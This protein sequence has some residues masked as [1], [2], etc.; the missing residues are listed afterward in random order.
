M[1]RMMLCLIAG[2]LFLA[3][4]AVS[5]DPRY[6]YEFPWQPSSKVVA[7][8]LHQA[9][10]DSPPAIPTSK[11]IRIEDATMVLESGV[12]DT[13]YIA[14]DQIVHFKF[15]EITHSLVVEPGAYLLPDSKESLIWVH[16]TGA[17]IR[18]GAPGGEFVQ[19]LGDGSWKKNIHFAINVAWGASAIMR[20]VL[21]AGVQLG[22]EVATERGDRDNP[23]SLDAVN[24]YLTNN[25]QGLRVLGASNVEVLQAAIWDN[26]DLAVYVSDGSKNHD[27]AVRFQATESWIKGKSEFSLTVPSS[28]VVFDQCNL[29]EEFVE[30]LYSQPDDLGL[31][32]VT[33][34]ENRPITGVVQTWPRPG[35]ILLSMADFTGNGGVGVEDAELF[36]QAFGSS[37]DSIPF[38][39]LYD[40]NNDGIVN[41]PDM[42]DLAYAFAGITR[43]EPVT[44]LATSPNMPEFLSVITR[45]PAIVSA[46][47]ADAGFG[48][49]VQAYLDIQTAVAAIGGEVPGGFTLSQNYPNPFNPETTIRF[50]LPQEASV[51]LAVYNT[52]G[53]VVARL[54]DEAL[55]S[56]NY[57]VQW[58]GRMESG[59]LAASGMYFYRLTAEG[60]TQTHRM[61][62]VR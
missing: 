46:A 24:L 54:V 56:G 38:G 8:M 49:I 2:I 33:V 21:V 57:N 13:V 35:K 47:K 15:V 34:L 18:I 62:L 23:S 37:R 53:Q 29:D 3:S 55:P 42:L 4:S 52:A 19:I 30:W 48:P 20:N 22:M 1:K 10:I 41:L 45:Y 6:A 60:Y 7:N 59:Q 5:A 26:T 17:T 14:A 16:T 36:S 43:S 11:E 40:M 28:S 50:S 12:Y 61:L 51:S 25:M 9:G 27:D 31:Q 39:T 44:V 32:R 58:D